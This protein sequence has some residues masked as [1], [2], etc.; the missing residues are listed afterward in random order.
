MLGLTAVNFFVTTE[1]SF[2]LFNQAT[3]S[4]ILHQQIVSQPA[5]AEAADVES[6]SNASLEN[7]GDDHFVILSDSSLLNPASPI[8]TKTAKTSSGLNL[9]APT[10]GWNWGIVHPTNAVDIANDCGTPIYAAAEGMVTESVDEGYNG[11]YGSYI[12]IEHKNDIETVYGHLDT[13]LTK[14]GTYVLRGD[15]IGTM[16]NTGKTHGP[17]GCH[18]HFEVHGEDNPL[19]K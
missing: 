11:G 6:L 1:S 7:S 4:N 3:A 19:A 14:Q 8:Q 12:K 18:L 15:L 13:I 9:L 10:T 16:G 17:T 2:P 5:R